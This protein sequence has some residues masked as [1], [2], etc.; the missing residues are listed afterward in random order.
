MARQTVGKRVGHWV[1]EMVAQS[2]AL[3]DA[4]WAV[5]RAV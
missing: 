2:V 5:A 1:V 4:S 3:T